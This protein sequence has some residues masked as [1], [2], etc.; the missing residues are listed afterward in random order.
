MGARST[1]LETEG[2]DRA[3]LAAVRKIGVGSI[4]VKNTTEKERDGNFCCCL[5]ELSRD[6]SLPRA[7][8]QCMN[9]P[10]SL[11]SGPRFSAP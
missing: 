6:R 5:G 10:P 11:G 2:E 7:C 9:A 4:E 3:R 8:Q 1:A